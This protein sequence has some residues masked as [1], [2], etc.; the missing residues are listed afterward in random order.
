MPLLSLVHHANNEVQSGANM[1]RKNWSNLF[2]FM[3]ALNV[4]LGVVP[5]NPVKIVSWI[6]VPL[7]VA[8]GVIARRRMI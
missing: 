1:N 5:S 4:A 8:M 2:I 6:A 3:G 7:C